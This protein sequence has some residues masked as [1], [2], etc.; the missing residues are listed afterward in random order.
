MTADDR[1]RVF[2]DEELLVLAR[3]PRQQVARDLAAGRV[4]AARATVVQAE[5]DLGAQIDRYTHWI[6]TL[7][8]HAAE[9]HGPTG[10]AAAIHATRRLFASHPDIGDAGPTVPT[11]V[12]DELVARATVGE[13]AEALEVLDVALDR[14]RTLVDLY[15]DW[16]SALLSDLYR[17]HGV[18][19]LEEAHR[20]VG[21]DTMRHLTAAVDGPFKDQAAGFVRLLTAHFSEV[22]LHEDEDKLTI[23]QDPCG[24]CGRQVAQGR[25][26]PPVDLAVV[27]EDHLSTWGR[28]TTTVYRTHV[29]VWH[30]SV[31]TEVLGAPWPVNQCPHGEVAGPCTILLYKDPSDPQ[32]RANVPG[33]RSG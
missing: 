2:T 32:A 10:S 22:E 12:V 21:A 33:V 24:T 7:F 8:A 11:S 25:H 23:V 16:I 3:S 6:S 13:V 1:G 14:W 30:V 4:G 27:T 26:R 15:R 9:R 29:P 17:R 5:S 31:A 19:E 20:R 28:G 18:D